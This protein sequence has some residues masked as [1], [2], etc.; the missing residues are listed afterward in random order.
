VNN[1]A[2]TQRKKIMLRYQ[3]VFIALG[4][5]MFSGF[6]TITPSAY[7]ASTDGCYASLENNVLTLGNNHIRRSFEWNTGDLKAISIVDVQTGGTLVMQDRRS[8][9]SLGNLTEN[10][11][12]GQWSKRIIQDAITNLH[13]QV[14]ITTIYDH[15]DVRRVFRIYP[16]CAVIGCDYYLRAHGAEIS[17]FKS[18]ET[19]LQLLRLPG[20]HWSYKAIEF[21]DRTDRTNTLVRETSTLA[22]L[23]GTDLRG[24]ILFGQNAVE[25]TAVFMVKEAPCSLVQLHYPGYD[26]TL[27]TW[28]VRAVGMG[29]QATDLPKGKWVRTY[30]LATGVCHKSEIAFLKALRVYQK[31][32]R[33]YVPE[34]DD[35][36]M[37]NTWGDRNKDARIG[38]EFVNKEVDACVRLGI[39]H[40]QIDDGW[41]QG[42]SR[43]SAQGRGKLWDLWEEKNWQPHTE[44]FPNGFAPVVKHAKAQG[45]DLGLWFHPSNAN[46]YANWERDAHIVVNLYRN[47]GIRYFKIDG[48]KL[49][50]K[51]SEINLRRFFDRIIRDSEGQVVINMDATADNRTGYHYFN[52]Y[53]NIFLE[54]RYTDFGRY[55][56]YWTLRNLWMLSKYVPAERLQIEFLNKWRNAHKYEKDDP[57]APQRVPFGYVFAVTLMAQPLAWFEGSGLPEEAYTIAP[58]IKAYRQHQSYIHQGT[59]LP[60]GTKPDGTSWTGFQSILNDKEGYL[61]I[62][63]EYNSANHEDI[64]LYDLAGKYIHCQHL[65]GQ[66]ADFSIKVNRNGQVTFSLP[67]VYSFGL[68]RYLIKE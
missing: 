58:I 44:R 8:D 15:I 55:Y 28:G 1:L 45:I 2:M 12:S 48:I 32:Q 30:G 33:R 14:E 31:L 25:D 41:Q 3:I 11:R 66:G 68:Y 21:F 35:M 56:P 40:L 57:L 60:I 23:S 10:V 52:E 53:G 50:N 4:G 16:D 51:Q 36:I 29:V 37:M 49:P 63:R 27:S 6:S 54:N 34:R 39:S 13:L 64:T 46:D 5:F 22:F 62:F 38:E 47:Y 17:A 24:N 19:V 18:E 67:A 65:C 9:I 43:N 26:Y 61:L 59:I 20:V 7:A 42:L